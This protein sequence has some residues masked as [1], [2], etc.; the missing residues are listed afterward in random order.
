MLFTQRSSTCYRRSFVLLSSSLIS[1]PLPCSIL[2][3]IIWLLCREIIEKLEWKSTF[4]T[5]IA[6]IDNQHRELLNYLNR[7]SDGG[8]NTDRKV[9]GEVF[10]GMIDYTLSHFAFEESLMEQVEY[11]FASAHKNVHSMLIKR[12]SQ[13]HE[14]FNNGEDVTEELYALLKRW[15]INHIQRDDAAYVAPVKAYLDSLPQAEAIS[16][17]S[18]ES[19]DKPETGSPEL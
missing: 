14:R 8:L 4:D 15:L 9:V 13:F 1:T 17:S 5:G 18:E 10:E 19:L 7:L 3:Y 16:G 11:P 2:Y 12:V 6:E